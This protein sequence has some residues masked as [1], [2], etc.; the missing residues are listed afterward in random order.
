MFAP[1]RFRILGRR[2]E[3]RPWAWH[4][5]GTHVFE[6][7]FLTAFTSKTGFAVTAKSGGG[8]EQVCAVDPH[9]TGLDLAG[10]VQRQVDVVAPYAG[11]QAVARIICQR[12][13]LFRRAEG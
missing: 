1:L 13:R 9:G 5:L 2:F 11:R 12:D 6:Q 4:P 10:R 8:V 3:L 7:T